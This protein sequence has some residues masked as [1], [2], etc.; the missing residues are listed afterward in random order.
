[1]SEGDAA[2]S[3]RLELGGEGVAL[4]RFDDPERAVNVLSSAALGRFEEILGE[5]EGLTGLRRV[6]VCSAKPGVFVAGADVDEFARV[7]GAAEAAAASRRG[8]EAFDRLSRLEALT[9][10]AI[11][12]TCLG[13]GLELALACDLRVAAEDP[14]V[15][16]GL[17]EVRLG[18][19]PGFGGTQRLP[20]LVGYRAAA[21][22]IL[23]GGSLDARRALRRGLVDRLVPLAELERAALETAPPAR[24]PLALPDRLLAWNR[25]L[26]SLVGRRI[27]ARAAR[28]APEEEMPAP[29]RALDL[30]EISFRLP[31]EQGLELEAETLGECLVGEASRNLVFLFRSRNELRR[32]AAAWGGAS[33]AKVER[34]AVA[35][36]GVMGA[37]IAG[38]ALDAGC[39][40]LLGDIDPEAVTSGRGRIES[41]LGKRVERGRL[42]AAEAARRLERLESLPR[43]GE[44]GGVALVIEAIVEEL[45]AKRA[46]LAGLET[47]VGPGAVLAT[48]TS[49]L[50]VADLAEGLERP[51]RLV[52]MHFF[53]PVHRMPLVELV[54]SPHS[55]PEA[56][57][58]AAEL[59]RRMGKVPVVV[60]DG[61][62]FLVNRLLMPYLAEAVRL[63]EEGIGFE[64]VDRAARR[65]GMPMGPLALLDAIGLDVALRAGERLREAFG[66]RAGMPGLLSRLVEQGRLG[67]KTGGGFYGPEGRPAR[68]SA[69]AV[70]GYG[71]GRASASDLRDRLALAL[72]AEASRALEEGIASSPRDLDMGMIL[73]A[74]F[75]PWKGGPLRWVDHQGAG[76][77]VGRMEELAA[78]H[79]ECLAPPE[80]L[81][82][83]ALGN[84]LFYQD[85]PRRSAGEVN[86]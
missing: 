56:V 63:V 20:R 37:G 25:W 74:G 61:P 43:E 62:G 11:G 73:G 70:E 5:I 18:I 41:G 64:T 15:S 77:V 83:M 55:E 4:I 82:R 68:E 86:A 31:L 40:V 21:E 16:L 78:S 8:Q 69:S 30:I 49:S 12:G 71:Q 84:E 51:G 32:E 57:A 81:A 66:E 10:A 39:H 42:S 27:R 50:S 60:R 52:G 14:A 85:R 23:G 34:L 19:V 7:R 24:R 13:G 35:G 17:P 72:V 45:S 26:R 9:V 1:M 3:P 58:T 2:A 53:H 28:H 48:N 38:A 22:L 44:L 67:A 79:G 76:A 80:A 36:A 33:P 54:P 47:R 6:V 65:F 29:F 59:A 75:P 46:L